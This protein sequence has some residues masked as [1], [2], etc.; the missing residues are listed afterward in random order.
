M[1][2]NLNWLAYKLQARSLRLAN[3]KYK[4]T[5]PVSVFNDVEGNAFNM[6]FAPP[7]GEGMLV[8]ISSIFDILPN[9]S[10]TEIKQQLDELTKIRAE[11]AQVG[12]EEVARLQIA[13]N[14]ANERERK[15]N[16]P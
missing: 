16:R 1:S 15:A 11:L 12:T 14:Q 6:R 10:K 8:K 9:I 7:D 5:D 2:S 13:L 4:A 3:P